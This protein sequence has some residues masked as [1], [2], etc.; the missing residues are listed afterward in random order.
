MAVVSGVVKGVPKTVVLS[1]N[2]STVLQQE[3]QSFNRTLLAREM[4]GRALQ[5]IHLLEVGLRHQQDL[6][7]LD[8][9][10]HRGEVERG[11]TLVAVRVHLGAGL[12]QGS[13]TVEVT[14]RRSVVKG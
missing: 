13:R 6:D 11:A 14:D 8:V 12:D 1:V 9:V 7:D 4:E 3:V 10:V 5:L 2:V